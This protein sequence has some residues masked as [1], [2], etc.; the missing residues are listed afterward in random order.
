MTRTTTDCW[1][2]KPS[3]RLDGTQGVYQA[4]PDSIIINSCLCQYLQTLRAY[5]NYYYCAFENGPYER[6]S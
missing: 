3:L 1:A 4:T 2:C 6:I 5:N